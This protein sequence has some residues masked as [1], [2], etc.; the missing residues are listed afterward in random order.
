[1]SWVIT[2]N[3]LNYFETYMGYNSRR[4]VIASILFNYVIGL[5]ATVASD[6]GF[7]VELIRRDSHKSLF[8]NADQTSK[9][10]LDAF[11]PRR[12]RKV[13]QNTL[14][15][16]VI[17]YQIGYIN[18]LKL[19]IGTPPIDFYG[20]VDTGRNC[21]FVY[22]IFIYLYFINTKLLLVLLFLY[23]YIY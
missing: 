20:V 6:G 11:R 2:H 14:Q 9:E 22:F 3:S 18:M 15:S 1:V 23:I 19:S 13:L 21:Y 10:H 7:T 5:L 4:L 16:E 17:A 8:Y 12:M